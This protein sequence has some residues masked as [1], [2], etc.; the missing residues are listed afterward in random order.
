[1]QIKKL[2]SK[3]RTRLFVNHCQQGLLF[4]NKEKEDRANELIISIKELIQ[5]EQRK[6]AEVTALK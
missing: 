2:F 1:L 6:A 5:N 4:R 3:R